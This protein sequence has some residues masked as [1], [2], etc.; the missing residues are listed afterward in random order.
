MTETFSPTLQRMDQYLEECNRDLWQHV[1]EMQL[2]AGEFAFCAVVVARSVYKD[3]RSKAGLQ[4]FYGASLSC[5]GWA[6]RRIMIDVSCLETWHPAVAYAV[7]HGGTGKAIIFPDG[8][9]SK[10]MRFDHQFLQYQEKPPCR[11]CRQ[12]FQKVNFRPCPRGHRQEKWQ[13]G[14]C[15]ET[16]A[17]SK[18]L[19][20]NRAA[21]EGIRSSANENIE[22]FANVTE[23]AF[24]ARVIE[25]LRRRNFEVANLQF[26]EPV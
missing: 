4:P 21:S 22:A 6:Q 16:E 1:Q 15:A 14:N 12:M 23:P 17:F 18:L 9:W 26:F 8:V 24:R 25:E 3:P 11:K 7:Y 20:G 13:Y 19:Q 10:A 5:K 2:K